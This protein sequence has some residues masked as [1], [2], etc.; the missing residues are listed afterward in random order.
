MSLFRSGYR[1]KADG[2]PEA[3]QPRVRPAHIRMNLAGTVVSAVLLTSAMASVCFAENL[4][5]PQPTYKYLRYDEDYSYLK[6]PNCRIDPLD[7]VKFIALNEK[8]DWFLSLG[9]EL[10]E[11]V[12][13]FQN[14]TWGQDPQGSA[15]L[16]QRYMAHFD[17]HMG[18]RVRFFGQLKSGLENG[19]AGG[20]RVIDE[21]KLDLH[22]A[23]VDLVLLSPAR[24]S[25]KLRAGRQELALGARRLVSAREGPNVRQ[26]FDGVRLILSTNIWNIDILATRPVQ[27][28]VGF[29]DDLP[30]PGQTLWGIYA[31]RSLPSLP[32]ANVDFF[33]L[34]LDRTRARFQQGVASETR[35]SFGARL[36][37]RRNGWDYDI[38]PVY[39]AGSF[40]QGSIRAG[41]I[42][43]ETGY[44]MQSWRWSPRLALRADAA[45]GDRDPSNP[46][47][48]TFNPLFPRGLYHQLVNLNGHVNFFDLDPVLVSRLNQQLSLTLDCGF[49]WRESRNDG[50]YGVGGNLLRPGA[51][52]KARYL[53]TQ[54]SAIAEWHPQRHITVIGIYTHSSPGE[55]LR[56]TGPSERV[57]YF[58][59]WLSYKF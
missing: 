48:Q 53:A 30:V 10:R 1:F 39:Q 31:A 54:P 26:S 43:T 8:A 25:I 4:P 52:S 42:E 37:G 14:P 15:Y 27:T 22:Q 11:N 21:D 28:K 13:Y 46:D 41:A 9:G 58:S 38:E 23:F 55:F 36:W 51:G 7:I 18:S 49:F 34:G 47:L 6:N 19:R 24:H 59:I 3:A 57:N 44:T 32:G 35:H 50:V 17:L 33:Y 40:G 45:T 20:P 5:C 56:E 2:F 12:E 16:L 29:F